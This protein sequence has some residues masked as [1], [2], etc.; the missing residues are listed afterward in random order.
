MTEPL[1]QSDKHWSGVTLGE[2]PS[3][4][5][6]GGCLLC[7]LTM[8]ARELGT[9]PSL[10]PVHA[11]LEF[12]DA[13]AFHGDALVIHL[14]APTIGLD[15]PLADRVKAPPG[16]GAL[17][18]A[19]EDAIFAGGLAILHVD[20]DGDRP[21]GDAD[22]DH[23]VLAHKIEGNRLHC[24]DPAVGRVLLSWPGLESVSDV[25]WGKGDHRRYHVLAVRPVR[26][27]AT[28]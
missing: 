4:I 17:R 14:A 8:A 9:R 18:D 10:L 24:L 20:H 13:G 15:A 12:L 7:C 1:Y 27:A 6:R 26:R 28:H 5:G 23:F 3:T 21:G 25:V 11:N 19:V 16:S 22:G 2:G